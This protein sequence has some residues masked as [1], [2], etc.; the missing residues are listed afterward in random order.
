MS[1]LNISKLLLIYLTIILTVPASSTLLKH[2]YCNY[3]SV[4]RLFIDNKINRI[5]YP[6]VLILATLV[7][8]NNNN[9]NNDED[10]IHFMQMMPDLQVSLCDYYY[11]WNMY[12]FS[13]S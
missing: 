5:L 4:V 6:T 11:Q 12:N 3:T 8:H 2:K 10:N 13:K 7:E 9:N 1:T